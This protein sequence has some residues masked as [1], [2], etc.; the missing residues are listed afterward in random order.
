M[1]KKKDTEWFIEAGIAKHNGKYSYEKTIYENY[2]KKVC[3]TCPIHGDFWQTPD[4]HLHSEGCLKCGIE[5]RGLKRRV[6]F[7]EFEE[8]S[9]KV[10]NGK[11]TYLKNDF[12]KSDIKTKIICP[13]HGEFLQTPDSHMQGHGCPKCKAEKLA[14]LRSEEFGDF[15]EHA[16]KVH[17]DKY[18]YD[19][20]IFKD[21]QTKVCITCPIHGDF[22]QIPNSHLSGRGCPICKNSHLEEKTRNVLV[23]LKLK[24]TEQQRYDWLINE[25][26]MALDFYLPEF[27]VAIECQG[28]QH[29]YN[30]STHYNIEGR[31]EKR[32]ILDKLKN[33][34]CKKYGIPII[35]I[36]N[37]R[38]SKYRLDEQF[39]HM[40]DDALFIEDIEKDNS[41]LLD[42]ISET[43]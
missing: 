8:K 17:K 7:E 39:N 41:I 10:H 29:I 26:K 43:P 16:K 27:N 23:N 37:K 36:F 32:I 30:R 3:I 34:L 28:D 40:Y 18:N 11:Y 4:R 20:T 42:K 21:T 24:F 5:K 15:I 33:R 6:S 9:K 35:Y 14:K 12:Q 25:K 31:F 1:A 19:K 13:I 38:N 22:W 2:K